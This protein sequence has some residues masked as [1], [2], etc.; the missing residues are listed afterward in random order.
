MTFDKN[1]KE[2]LSHLSDTEKD[3]L[4]LR[5]LK[6]DVTLANRLRFELLSTVTVDERR[7]EVEKR[8]KQQVVHFSANF[9][10]VGYLNMDVRSLS[11]EINEHVKITKDVFGEVSLNILL[12]NETLTLNNSKIQRA[13]FGKAYKFCVAVIARIF[14]ILLLINKL[15]VDYRVDFEEGLKTLNTLIGANHYLMKTAIQNGFDVNWLLPDN[16]PEDIV[17]IHKQLRTN[18]YLR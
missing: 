17:A 8:I 6:K 5:L 9:Y 3:R 7:R 13:T 15:D 14:K 10:S 16:V 2:A 11:G 1:F 18:G 4:I 12:L